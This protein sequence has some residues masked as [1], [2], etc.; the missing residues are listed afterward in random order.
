[1][2]VF[3]MYLQEVFCIV[4]AFSYLCGNSLPMQKSNDIFYRYIPYT[5]V[6]TDQ[7]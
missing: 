1:M 3:R 4:M 5:H 6:V 7:D 2:L